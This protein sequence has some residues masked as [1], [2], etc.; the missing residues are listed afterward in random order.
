MTQTADIAIIGAGIAGLSLAARLAGTARVIVVEREEQPGYHAS[1]R[2]AAMFAPTFGAPA[3]RALARASRP[4]LEAAGVLSPR[5]LMM[6]ARADQIA[7]L[8]AAERGL[9]DIPGVRRLDAGAARVRAPLLREGY[10]AAALLDESAADIDVHALMQGHQRALRAGGGQVLT[11][12]EVHRIDRAGGGWRIATRTGTIEAGML[13]NAAGA[14]ADR[15]ARMAG[16]R[17]VG[18]VPRRRSALTVAA[19][20]GAEVAPL[21]MVLDVDE[22]FYLKPDAGRLLASPADATPTEPGDAA[23]EEIDLA[24][25]IDRI[26]RAFALRVRRIESRW[27]GLRSFAPDGL[28]VIG[29]D[30]ELAGFFWLAGQGGAGVETSPALSALAAALITG[31]GAAAA[32]A[33]T[34]LAGGDLS[35]GRPALVTG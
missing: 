20:E 4:A 21:P 29:A 17:P 7:A 31:E 5:G 10:A 27:A 24:L 11:R 30:P 35:P 33:G 32:L 13:V 28:P 23:P 14:W 1:G 19:P 6:V 2:S 18:I 25:C 15:L 26:E 8:D 9:S 34:G 22:A 12:A 16:A 3:W